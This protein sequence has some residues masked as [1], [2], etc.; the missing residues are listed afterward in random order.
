MD[1]DVDGGGFL[2]PAVCNI[3]M[4]IHCGAV[5][6]CGLTSDDVT[7]KF[8]TRTRIIKSK[9]FQIQAASY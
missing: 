5:R 9:K 6:S 8:E 4:I 1:V 2:T 3:C 7:C